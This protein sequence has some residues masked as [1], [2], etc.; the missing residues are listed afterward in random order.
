MRVALVIAALLFAACAE[1]GRDG[2]LTPQVG[3]YVGG[4]VGVNLR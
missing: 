1:R 3:G 2:G 4:N